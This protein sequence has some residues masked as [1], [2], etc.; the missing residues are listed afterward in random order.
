MNGCM[1][2]LLGLGVVLS[3]CAPA[4]WGG[5]NSLLP[6]EVIEV[7]QP[8]TLGTGE[9]V[10]EDGA[11]ALTAD[12]EAVLLDYF[13]RTYEGLAR[14]EAAD[15]TGLFSDS[16]QAE[17]AAAEV[18]L[19]VG[20]RTM[21]DGLDYALTAYTYTIHCQ[22]VA[23]QEDGSVAVSAM[24][25]STQNFVQLP[26][27]TSERSR[28]FHRFVLER[29]DGGWAIR[30]HMQHNAL[31]GQVRDL[32]GGMAEE[33][34]AAYLAAVERYL[35]TLRAARAALEAQR[36]EETALPA[37]EVAYDRA[38]A[39]AYAD[40]YAMDRN[41]DWVDYTDTGGN[42]QNFA[43]QCLLA[44]GIPMDTRG[45]A[46]WKWYDSEFS[47]APTAS[48]RSGSWASVTQFLDYAASNTGFGLAAE[49][50]APYF[51]G[52]PGDLLEMGTEEGWR[53]TVVIRDLVADETGETVDYLIHSNTNDMK[54]FP[55]SLYGYPVVIL[56]RIAGWKR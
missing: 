3:G 39:L 47:N 45:E 16:A 24:E 13:T 41:P 12:Q 17:I 50:D 30:S 19:Q 7:F 38:A 31:F 54:N 18:A 46:V 56:T 9:I 33:V 2:I 53:H 4:A 23:L 14:L 21:I 37:A 44:G 52:Q 11:P 28:T 32:A 27:I 35:D 34:P 55:A 42:C 22:D 20:M 10:Y 36:G 1:A 51:S 5:E 29:R 43:S 25:N 15:F 48:G 8:E 6:P 49:V 40:R 26:G